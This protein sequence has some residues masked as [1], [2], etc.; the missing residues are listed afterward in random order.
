MPP[1]NPARGALPNVTTRTA[2]QARTSNT[3]RTQEGIPEPPFDHDLGGDPEGADV[4]QLR[5]QIR[6]LARDQ[7]N[8]RDMLG[9][10]LAQLTALTAT[11]TPLPQ[12]HI[13]FAER[14]TS[15]STDAQDRIPRYSKKQPDPQPLSDGIDPTFESWKLQIQGKFRVNADHFEDEEARMFYLFNRTIG[16][17]QKHLRRRYDDDS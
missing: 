8:D 17:A 9:Q 13:R 5:E 10:I 1:K 7:I 15:I 2:S 16:D 4:A 6:T 12:D 3:S 14:D 11:Q